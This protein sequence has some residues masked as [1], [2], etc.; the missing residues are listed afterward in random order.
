MIG[1]PNVWR[2][3]GYVIPISG[4]PPEPSQGKPE[5]SKGV[6][7]NNSFS[8]SRKRDSAT[9]EISGQFEYAPNG[10]SGSAELEDT[11]EESEEESLA[12]KLENA[13]DVVVRDGSDSPLT[14]HDI[15]LSIAASMLLRM[16]DEVKNRF[17]YTTS[18]VSYINNL[19]N[20]KCIKKYT[21]FRVWHGINS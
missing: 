11:D 10:G 4:K 6:L 16:R 3:L 2:D 8:P 9:E 5:A 13:T 17:G 14:W 12:D 7:P 20:K 1:I 15:A 18:A 19:I 21:I